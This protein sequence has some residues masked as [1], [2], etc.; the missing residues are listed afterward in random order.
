M[1]AT[2]GWLWGGQREDLKLQGV[3]LR[4]EAPSPSHAL[5]QTPRTP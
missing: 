5:G 3:E 1:V 2:K 4:G